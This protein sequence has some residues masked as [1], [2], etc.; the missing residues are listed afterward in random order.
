MKITISAKNI[1]LTA[2]LRNV[3]EKKLSKLEKYFNPE[4]EVH[5]TLSTQ[6]TRQIV[7]VTIPFNGAFL[8][9][10]EENEDMYVSI[11]L[12]IDKL[13]GQIRKQKTKI[14]RSKYAK[15]IKYQELP[16]L[17]FK[18]EEEEA[19]I[20]KTK[21]FAMKPM[22]DEEA[23]LQMELV[24]H[25]FFVYQNADSGEVNVVYKRRDGNY[26]LIEPEF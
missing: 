25:N 22:S 20:V 11:D 2:A 5:A 24:G 13:E 10:Q 8:R 19:Q 4:V 3:V 12:I 1:E 17:S 16:S 18:E 26:G 7:E 23:V 21:K 15:G 9:A 14:E 6:K